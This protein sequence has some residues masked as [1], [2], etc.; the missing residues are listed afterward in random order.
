M[1]DVKLLSIVRGEG[2]DKQTLGKGYLFD[3]DYNIK[4]EFFTLELPWLNNQRNISCIPEGIYTVRKRYS[5]KYKN[6]L[7]VIGTRGREWILIHHGN[8]YSDIR[9]C[10]LVGDNHTD[11]DG[12][13]YKDVT[14]SIATMEKIMDIVPDEMKMQIS[15]GHK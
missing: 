10:I 8:F 3:E 9:G 14:N 13:G 6:H 12:D 2:S 4:L 7:H 11:I 5:P 1:S 15:Y